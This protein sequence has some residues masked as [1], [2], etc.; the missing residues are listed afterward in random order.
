MRC[1]VH[2]CVRIEAAEQPLDPI[3]RHLCEQHVGAARKILRERPATGRA[4]LLAE[5]DRVRVRA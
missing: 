1:F 5:L 3:Q 4:E 2:H